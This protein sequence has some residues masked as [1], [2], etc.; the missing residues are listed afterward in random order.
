MSQVGVQIMVDLFKKALAAKRESK[1]VEFKESF[2]PLSPGD[3]CELIKDIAAIANTG[4]GVIVF[5]VDSLGTPK[6]TSVEAIARIDPA[7]VSNK[8]AKYAAS[9]DIEFEVTS[10]TKAGHPVV[11]FVIQSATIPL[12]FEKPGTYDIGGGKQRTA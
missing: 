5:G 3:W 6:G 4:G 2:D 11:V 12:V 1:H 7:D 10:A 8:L 9:A